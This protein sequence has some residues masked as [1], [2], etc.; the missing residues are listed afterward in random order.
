SADGR[1]IGTFTCADRTI[2]RDLRS[3][4]DLL[5]D[6]DVVA[7]IAG[8]PHAQAMVAASSEPDAVLDDIS[9]ADDYTILDADSSQRSAID[10]V[11]RG[12]SLV[13]HGPPGTGKSQT[14]ANLTAPLVAQGR[15]G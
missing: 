13:I 15:R 6:S 12:Q 10:M 8:D 4:G 1:V 3:A 14:I 9:P 7:A 11:V 5:T 2:V